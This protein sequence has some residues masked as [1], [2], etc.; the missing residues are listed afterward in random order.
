MD[1][2]VEMEQASSM[3]RTRNVLELVKENDIQVIAPFI[4]SIADNS[5]EKLVSDYG[6][7]LVEGFDEPYAYSEFLIGIFLNI[8]N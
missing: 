7:C 8:L 2:L 1:I 3:I 6:N 5:K 4:E